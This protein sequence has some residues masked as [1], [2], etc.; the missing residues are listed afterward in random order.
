MHVPP[1]LSWKQS[2]TSKKLFQTV[3]EDCLLTYAN[4]AFYSIIYICFNI[5]MLKLLY[6][7][8]KIDT[9]GVIGKSPLFLGIMA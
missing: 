6:L 4:F 7:I 9:D 8:R 3:C 5:H 1:H 2:A